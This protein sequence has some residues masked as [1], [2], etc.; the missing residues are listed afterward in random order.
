MCVCVSVCVYV[1]VFIEI[2]T[3]THKHTHTHTHSH[4]QHTALS[5]DGVR[6]LLDG[7]VQFVTHVPPT[8]VPPPPAALSPNLTK[9]AP[10]APSAMY[11]CV[12]IRIYVYV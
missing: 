10:A 8:L 12:C 9:S 6:D 7:W 1:Y 3:Y 11:I 4:T 5:E 2:H